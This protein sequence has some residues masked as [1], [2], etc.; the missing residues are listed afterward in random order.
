MSA[1]ADR[2]KLQ[3]RVFPLGGEPAEDLSATTTPSERIAMV[4]ALSEEAWALTGIPMP[5]YSR[6]QMP[7]RIVPL[8]SKTR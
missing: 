2:S 8:A 6:D 4:T 3:V 5:D 1:R 7:I